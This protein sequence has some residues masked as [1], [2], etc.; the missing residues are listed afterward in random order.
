MRGEPAPR[1]RGRRAATGPR[2]TD[3]SRLRRRA[4]RGGRVVREQRCVRGGRA[5]FDSSAAATPAPPPVSLPSPLPS[6]APSPAAD[7]GPQVCPRFIVVFSLAAS[8]PPASAKAPAAGLARWIVAHPDVT[9]V[10]EGHADAV[11]SDHGNLELSRRRAAAV[12][13]LLER[14]GV[15]WSRLTVR[16]FGAFSPVEGAPEEAAANRRV[17]VQIRSAGECPF[18][19]AEVLGP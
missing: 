13:K 19:K 4:R 10:I 5:A 8:Q 14:E 18:S 11:G 12:G 6:L 9:A 16:G 7:A 1:R 15:A 17:V 2:W 3:G